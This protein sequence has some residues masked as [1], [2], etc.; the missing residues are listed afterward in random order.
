MKSQATTRLEQIRPGEVFHLGR[1]GGEMTVMSGRVWMT[2]GQVNGDHFLDP[3]D[4]VRIDVDECAIVEA[5][6]RG[7][8]ATVLWTPRAQT[9]VGR[10]VEEPLLG[11]AFITRVAARGLAALARRTA[12]AARRAQGCVVRSPGM[13][14]GSSD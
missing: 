7:G 11:L 4:T 8:S 3:G 1:L 6:Q 13:A 5:I 14:T 10:M 12:A 9:L 2:R